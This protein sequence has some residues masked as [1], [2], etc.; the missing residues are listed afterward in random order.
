MA[1]HTNNRGKL[2]TSPRSAR[3]RLWWIVGGFLLVAICVAVRFMWGP[4][5]ATA[6]A[7]EKK[8]PAIQQTAATAA[9]PE[10]QKKMQVVALVNGEKVTR[11]QLADEALLHYGNEVLEALLNKTLIL[12]ACSKRGIQVTQEEVAAEIDRMAQRFGVATDQ[13]LKMLKEE[14]QISAQQYAKDIIWPTVALRK[15][16]EQRV[17]P[18]EE[19][20]QQAFETQFGPSVQ[21]RLIVVSDLQKAR[22]VLGMANS[23]PANFGELAKKYSEDVSSA[24]AKGLIQPIRKHLGDANLERAAFALQEGQISDAIAVNNQYAILKCE[25]QLPARLPPDA[26]HQKNESFAQVR[27]TLWEAC[28]DKKMRQAASDIFG[29]LQRETRYEVVWNDPVRRKQQPG[30][31]AVVGARVISTTDLAE[32]C[33]ERNGMQT[34]EGAINRRML[35]QAARRHKIEVTDQDLDEEI[36][37][38]AATMGR[39]KSDGTPDIETWLKEVIEEQKTT[40]ELYRRDS[41]WPSVVLRRLVQDKVDVTAE[42]IQRGYEANY[43]PRM[44]IR[45]IVFHGN[46][47]RKAQEVWDMARSKPTL[48]NF[49]DLAAEY[50]VEATSR[51]LRGEVPPV[52]RWGGQPVL[53]REAFALKTGEIS[54]VFQMGE[55]WVIV[56][57]EGETKPVDARLDEVRQM[58]HA[59]VFEKKL[60]A[61]M[62]QEFVSM[63]DNSS[64]DNFLAGTSRSPNKGQSIDSI[65]APRTPGST[66]DSAVRPAAASVPMTNR[67]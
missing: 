66:V 50:S 37:R 33:I 27:R 31:A 26:L 18:T 38:A 36:A 20:V 59:E 13:W 28:R 23:D 54:G 35:E 2:S 49:C 7:P 48:E 51:V 63:Q 46:Q 14:R 65:V 41:V 9:T 12:D 21:A 57:C 29:E 60:R 17:Q 55:K 8:M 6:G 58:L 61:M 19:E 67:R 53:E 32:E 52:Q 44:R 25:R 47:L 15:L 5:A 43:G 64:V 22:E 1:Q 11:Q 16:A 24:S 34:L 42:D 45:A 62:A 10:E 40:V 4:S 56:Y 39:F 3:T 30:V